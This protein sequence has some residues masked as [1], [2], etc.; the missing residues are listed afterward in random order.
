MKTL[1][2]SVLAILFAILGLS[3]TAQTGYGEIRGIIKDNETLETVPF[4]T[5]KILQGN[6]LI[7][8][9]VTDIEGRYKYKP[10]TPGKYELMIIEPGHQTQPVN[11]IK[12]IPNEATYVDVKLTA[13]TLTTVVVVAAPIEYAPKGVDKTMYTFSS[14]DAKEVKQLASA[15][16]G[17]VK[18]MLSSISSNVVDMGDGQ[19][20]VRGARDGSTSYYVDGVRCL[21]ATSVP[22]GAIENLTFFTGGVP[23]MYGDMTSGAVLITT[24]SYFSGIRE[25]N[26]RN[27]EWR[28]KQETKRAAEKAKLD[29]ANR[30][31][32]IEEEKAKEKSE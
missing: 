2:T 7:G 28:D 13:N 5:V 32:E 4:A 10:L 21:G 6:V 17:D 15:N 25:K 20:H 14:L 9:V 24:K 30:A 16:P 11:N 3:A 12:V 23:A 31:K 19:I 29:E 1:T 22:G 18:G 26:I 27:Q 8:G